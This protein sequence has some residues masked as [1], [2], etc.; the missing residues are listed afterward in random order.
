M[1]G[2]LLVEGPDFMAVEVQDADN[3]VSGPDR[4]HDLRTVTGIAGYVR[5]AKFRDIPDHQWS[6]GQECL[7]TG[8]V[9]PDRAA[10]RSAAAGAEDQLRRGG[11]VRGLQIEACPGD[12]MSLEMRPCDLEEKILKRGSVSSCEPVGVEDSPQVVGDRGPSVLGG[13]GH[14]LIQS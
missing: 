12:A 6:P 4:D 14:V 5:L 7:T 8:S 10:C 1:P 9:K 3:Q 13:V 2:V 11:V